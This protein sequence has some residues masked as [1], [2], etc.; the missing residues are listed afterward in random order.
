MEQFILFDFA[1]PETVLGEKVQQSN[2]AEYQGYLSL[3]AKAN[4]YADSYYNRESEISDF[5]YDTLTKELKRIEGAHPEWVSSDS[6]TQKVGGA[7][8]TV[9]GT[10]VLTHNVP[11]LSID[12]VFDRESVQQFC[13]KCN[14]VDAGITFS[15]EHKIDGLSLTCRYKNI[16]GKL[17]LTVAELRGNGYEGEEVPLEVIKE[18]KGIEMV[19]NDTLSAA[20]DYLE[21]R[22]EVAMSKEDFMRYYNEC[23]LLG[24]KLPANCRNLASGTIRTMDA[25]IVRERGLFAL[26]FNVQAYELKDSALSSVFD[27]HTLALNYLSENNIPVVWHAECSNF[28]Q[29]WHVISNIGDERALLPYEIDGAVVKV[30]Q[31][32][33]RQV[34]SA[35]KKNEAGMKAY[36]Y[37][38]EGVEITLSDVEL[39]VGRTGKVSP[40]AVF[41]EVHICGTMVG[42]ATLHNQDYIKEKQIGINGRYLLKKGGEII[43]AIVECIQPPKEIFLYPDV[44]P[45]CGSPLQ[46]E[47]GKADYY[48]YNPAC[49]AQLVQAIEFFCSRDAMDIKALGVSLIEKLVASGYVES[50]CDLYDLHTYKADLVALGILG[51]E[52][53]TTK[54]LHAIEASKKQPAERLLTALGIRGVGKNTAKLLLSIYSDIEQLAT[55][56]ISELCCIDGIGS[57]I[58]TNIYNFFHNPGTRNLYD[59]LKQAGVTTEKVVVSNVDGKLTGLTFCITGTLSKKRS[60]IVTMIEQNGGRESGFSKSISYLIAGEDAGSKLQKALAANV[61]VITEEEF[62]DMIGQ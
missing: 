12:D 39:T 16:A 38:Q 18:I 9:A 20:L 35:S 27:V 58:A 40:T 4:H 13:G 49:S 29:V 21:I 34:F 5:E 45:E 15:V 32:H 11:M 60:D 37:P 42:R 36:K 2:D 47:E 62:L 6:P 7:V 23:E 43:P 54:I 56:S 17:R 1:S 22:A 50:Y 48:C 52:Q 33:K 28:E 3:V 59:K 57:S 25:E 44:C 46:R 19:L 55:A 41:P 61:P 24:K 51:R 31:I 53:N 30:N 26:F 10:N 14:S 8:Q